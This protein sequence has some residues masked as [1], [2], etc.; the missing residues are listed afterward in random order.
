M[1]RSGSDEAR[2]LQLVKNMAD[3]VEWGA[4]KKIGS[5]E[6]RSANERPT[7]LTLDGKPSPERSVDESFGGD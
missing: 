1:V 5:G 6:A 4:P 2:R 3:E 7:A